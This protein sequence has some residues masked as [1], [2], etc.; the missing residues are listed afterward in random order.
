MDK[1]KTNV[2][3]G[4][5][6]SLII[7]KGEE[8]EKIVK[9]IKLGLIKYTA[10]STYIGKMISN[11]LSLLQGVLNNS[12]TDETFGIDENT[13]PDK[14]ASKISDFLISFINNNILEVIRIIDL[15]TDLEYEYIAEEVSLVDAVNILLK[16]IEVNELKKFENDIKNLLRDLRNNQTP[17]EKK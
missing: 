1:D 6:K 9:V 7:N 16:I 15:C 3:L 14:R 2:S 5:A 13:P 8:N 10:M 4:T 12:V 17:V 11:S